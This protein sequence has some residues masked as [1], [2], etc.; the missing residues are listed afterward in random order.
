[1]GWRFQTK[2]RSS[3]EATNKHL[4]DH[5]ERF[6]ARSSHRARDTARERAARHSAVP[7]ARSA[8]HQ[9]ASALARSEWNLLIVPSLRNL[10]IHLHPRRVSS[11]NKPA[12]SPSSALDIL[13]SYAQHPNSIHLSPI[14][15]KSRRPIPGPRSARA[16]KMQPSRRPYTTG[17]DELILAAKIEESR[18][19]A[20]TSAGSHMLAPPSSVSNTSAYSSYTPQSASSHSSCQSSQQPA[21][22]APYVPYVP[23]VPTGRGLGY[24]PLSSVISNSR[25]AAMH[26]P[27]PRNKCELELYSLLEKANLLQY[28]E[29]FLKY[30]GDD[31]Q[32]L[33][34]A[35][36]EE[37]IEIMKLIGMTNK[38]LHIRRLQKVLSD[39]RETQSAY[40]AIDYFKKPSASFTSNQDQSSSYGAQ[41]LYFSQLTGDRLPFRSSAFLVESPAP[42]PTSSEISQPSFVASETPQQQQYC[43]PPEVIVGAPKR[44][45]LMDSIKPRDLTKTYHSD[46]PTP[47]LRQ[48]SVR[49]AII[50]K[51]KRAKKAHE[52][53]S[54]TSTSNRSYGDDSKLTPTSNSPS[55]P[56][57]DESPR[58]SRGS[59]NASDQDEGK[60]TQMG[61]E[62]IVQVDPVSRRKS[63]VRTSLLSR[64]NNS[65]KDKQL[66]VPERPSSSPITKS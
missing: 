32:Q 62:P 6:P 11:I 44:P 18:S 1:M 3:L 9:R 64:F 38:P 26:L 63:S 49:Q 60:P 56:N 12:A 41:S 7:G 21:F 27:T 20:G 24:P 30:G 28:F 55:P 61:D 29:T 54:R 15:G 66:A 46:M 25:D 65:A 35:D 31:V 19:R 14:Q 47:D 10:I 57:W 51:R 5:R 48:L 8:A 33:S 39:W 50:D 4:P 45:R 59:P 36:E 42:T 53:P 40:E 23:Y 43:T 34:D 2:D 22:I 17:V 37:F 16:S 58:S 52:Q 13:S